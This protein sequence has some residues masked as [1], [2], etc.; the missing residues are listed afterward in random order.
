MAESSDTAAPRK[1]GVWEWFWR[2]S[3]LA[4]A[5]EQLQRVPQ[6]RRLLLKRAETALELAGRAFDP[7]DAL[8]SGPS[9]PLAVSLYREAAYWALCAQG[10]EPRPNDNEAAFASVD[11]PTLLALAG[12]DEALEQLRASFVIKSFRQ[13]ADDTAEV[14]RS[15]AVALRTFAHA[16]IQRQ[17]GAE[18]RVGR[19]LVRRWLRVSLTL[20]ALLLL[21]LSSTW[22]LRMATQGPDLAAGKPRRTS[23]VSTTWSIQPG[24]FEFVT[25]EEDGPWLEI[26]LQKPTQFSVVDVINRRDCCQER[27]LPTLIEVSRDRTR[28]KEVMRRDET[29][30]TWHAQFA[31]TTARYV[32]IRVARHSF[33]HLAGVAVRAR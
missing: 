20:L 31:P 6:S 21:A 23:S 27:A 15:D 25:N 4:Q 33:L 8:R 5:R 1:R 30:T 11:S 18:R 7:V 10:G 26:D 9:L 14:Q 29:Y 2:G 17:L 12:G 22:L 24:N 28:W 16:L 19:A 32:R 3:E 13:T